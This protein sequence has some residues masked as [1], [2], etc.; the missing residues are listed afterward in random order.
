MVNYETANFSK[1]SVLKANNTNRNCNREK[2]LI[3]NYCT[4]VIMILSY[5]MSKDRLHMQVCQPCQVY[6][7]LI[8]GHFSK[9]IFQCKQI[10]LGSLQPELRKYF[11]IIFGTKLMTSIM[12][13]EIYFK[14]RVVKPCL[15]SCILNLSLDF[16][17]LREEIHLQYLIQIAIYCYHQ[18][19]TFKIFC[20]VRITPPRNFRPPMK[21]TLTNRVKVST[22]RR[23]EH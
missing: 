13:F 9:K 19:S 1:N 10:L 18:S 16:G 6:F 21:S 5:F 17:V 7:M 2:R 3:S 14:H 11:P 12:W 8:Q 20:R 4:W 15:L 22:P 23:I